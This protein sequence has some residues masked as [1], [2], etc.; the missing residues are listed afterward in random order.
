MNYQFYDRFIPSL[1]EDF[2]SGNFASALARL[3]EGYSIYPEQATILDFWRIL[4]FARQGDIENALSVMEMTI[5]KGNWFSEI[6][7][8]RSPSTQA[9]Q[10]NPWFEKLIVLNQAN[11][12]QDQAGRF[13]YYV[14]RPEGKCKAG[15]PPCPALIGLHS[16]GGSVASSLDFWKPAATLGWITAALQS[17]QALMRGVSIWDDQDI[18]LADIRQDIDSLSENYSLNPWQTILAGHATSSETAIRLVISRKI[19][20]DKF[21]VVNPSGPG[22]LDLESW[23]EF[24]KENPP[25]GIQG[26]LLAGELDESVPVSFVSDFV[27]FLNHAG[28][29]VELE[30][31][32]GLDGNYQPAYDDAV[33]R[34]LNFLTG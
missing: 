2:S 26:Y 28:A 7:L 23:S 10:G 17:S 27:D 34:A 4:L 5:D 9:L 19:E 29:K 32:S 21:F 31:V 8:R 30:F 24:I 22:L 14:L 16:N 25:D 3:E 20:I 12:D 11:A 13:P 15:G 18:A 1:Q 33:T 6:L